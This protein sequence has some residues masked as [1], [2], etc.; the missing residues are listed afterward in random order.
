MAQQGQRKRPNVPPRNRP[1][2]TR[3]RS[4]GRL[5]TFQFEGTSQLNNETVRGEVQAVNEQDARRQLLYRNV[6]I[7]RLK[8]GKRRAR[9][10][11]PHD[12]T[13]FTRQLGSMLKAG[14]TLTQALTIIGRGNV[15]STMANMVLAIRNDVEQG[16]S[17]TEALS[18][19]PKY[20]DNLYLGM[21]EAGEGGGVLENSLDRISIQREKS[22]AMVSSVRKALIYP[23]FVIVVAFVVMTLMLIWILP[24]FKSLYDEMGAALPQITVFVIALSDFLIKWGLLIVA[25]IALAVYLFINRY[26]NSPAFKERVTR[27]LMKIPVLGYI[28]QRLETARWARTFASLYGAGLPMP[29]ILQLITKG[30]KNVLFEKATHQIE[31]QVSQ[32]ESLVSS[33]RSLGSLFPPLFVQLAEVGEEA[34]TLDDMMSKAAE[35]F[36]DEVDRRTS[37]LASVFE[38][39]IIVVLAVFIGF[40][41]LAMYMPI[42]NM[43]S[44]V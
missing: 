14:L 36:E 28:L 15:N 13:V 9:K 21:I 8:Q 38:P 35:Y 41:L 2:N 39:M 5:K 42:F 23:V 30:A 12:I 33:M 34:G 31:A 18:R 44:T 1:S 3:R 22:A 24:A 40:I 16:S 20:F 25:L 29:E 37:T 4:G 43:A 26:R 7:I 11:K 10:I 19:Y 17:F 27:F 6:K 32:G